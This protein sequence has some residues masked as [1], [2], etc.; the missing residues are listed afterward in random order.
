MGSFRG[1]AVPGTLFL[2]VGIWHT[3]NSLLKY[4][5]NPK[6]FQ[7]RVWHALPRVTGSL[8]FLELYI[9]TLGALL[10]LCIEFFYSPHFQYFVDGALNAKHL[11]NFEHSAM[12]LMFFVLGAVALFTEAAGVLHLPLG[13]LNIIAGMAFTAEFLLFYFHSTTH[14]GL[15]G[16]YHELLVYLIGLCILFSCLGAAFPQSFIVDLASGISITL[17]GLWFYVVAMA[18]YGSWVPLGCKGSETGIKCDAPAYETRGQSLANSQFN[19]LIVSVLGAVT[20]L[21]AVAA[22]FKGHPDV[23]YVDDFDAKA[24][25]AST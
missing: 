4:V 17:Q 7:G 6:G 2:V 25:A 18:L 10:D 23:F 1:H 12:L 15:E 24:A 19:F 13:A 9:I 21:Y 14:A 11:N 3:L 22:H 16:R 20:V 8:R 5:S